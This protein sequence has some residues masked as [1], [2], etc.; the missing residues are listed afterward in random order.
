MF[1]F[2]DYLMVGAL[3]VKN[4]EINLLKNR[5]DIFFYIWVLD[6]FYILFS[7]RHTKTNEN[8]NV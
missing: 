1:F 7:L 4:Y 5:F 8:F 2:A 6:I 3:I